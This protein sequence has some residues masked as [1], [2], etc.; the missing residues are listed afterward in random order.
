MAY[1]AEA[2]H[3]EKKARNQILVEKSS[4][5]NPSLNIAE[6][7]FREK[8]FLIVEK[9]TYTTS[10][11][12][13]IFFFRLV[14]DHFPE[15]ADA[16]SDKCKFEDNFQEC[17]NGY[18]NYEGTRMWRRPMEYGGALAKSEHLIFARLCR[19]GCTGITY[20]VRYMHTQVESDLRDRGELPELP[21]LPSS[22]KEYSKILF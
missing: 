1:T 20:F 14:L 7:K 9:H 3:V 8:L 21:Q 5:P 15:V 19:L 6:E 4:P 17:L 10:K 16:C 13:Y 11:N 12:Q 2:E 22:H 18:E